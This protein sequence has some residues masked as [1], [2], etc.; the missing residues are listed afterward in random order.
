MTLAQNWPKT[1]TSL[2]HK[3][4]ILNRIRSLLKERARVFLLFITYPQS[5]KHSRPSSIALRTNDTMN[6][7]KMVNSTE[8]WICTTVTVPFPPFLVVHCLLLLHKYWK[9]HD[10]FI[11][12]YY[13]GQLL[14]SHFFLFEKFSTWIW[15]FVV[16]VNVTLYCPLLWK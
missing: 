14:S 4:L 7:G 10:S 6:K 1:A 13:F 3:T 8:T 15:M 9:I 11:R 16:A 2:W 12:K 5:F